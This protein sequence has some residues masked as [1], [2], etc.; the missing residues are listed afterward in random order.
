M[1]KISAP[2]ENKQYYHYS[3]LFFVAVHVFI[4]VSMHN[5]TSV[6]VSVWIIALGWENAYPWENQVSDHQG[7]NLEQ[8]DNIVE[9]VAA[10]C[11][12]NGE[13]WE[14]EPTAWMTERTEEI[15]LFNLWGKL[16][17]LRGIA[18]Q[19]ASL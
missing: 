3:V 14:S 6:F 15:I 13:G 11:R 19:A 9:P 2:V 18:S 16:Q 10:G 7:I 17:L 8:A 4:V 12:S 5:I 1:F